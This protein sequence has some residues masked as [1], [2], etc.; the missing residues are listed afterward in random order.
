VKIDQI[1]GYAL[2]SLRQRQLRSWLTILGVVIGIAAIV[3]LLTI[4]EGFNQQVQQQLSALGENTVFVVPVAES[5]G[6]S[7]A[8]R[9][10]GSVTTSGKL[11]DEDAERLRRI[12]EIEE[13]AR[14]LSGRGTI[15]F[16][17]KEI[18]STVQGIEPGIFEKTTLVEIEEGRFLEAHDRR[19]AVVGSS[20]A[21]DS[22]GTNRIGV[23]S[24]ILI[25]GKKFRVIG[26]L[27]KTGGGFGPA[28]Q[29]DTAILVHFEDAQE[30]FQES[31]A[32]HEV[33]AIVLTL[34]EGSD[35]DDVTEK[36]TSEIAASHRIRPEDKDFSV[37]NPKVIQE[38]VGSILGLVTAF[39]GAIASISLLVG[40]VGIANV[41]F[42]SVVERTREIGVLKAV[43][44]KREDILRIFVFESAAL[45]GM[46]GGGGAIVGLTVVYPAALLGFP[47][48]IH[49]EIV[50]FALIFSIAVGFVSGFVPARRAAELSPV[51]ALRYE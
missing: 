29:M 38:Q 31:L 39:L 34:R 44:A 5:Q 26:I 18:S 43:G 10:P 17:E 1:A 3:S 24:F 28:A 41:M 8:F 30:L 6:S 12:P 36:I 13:I 19:V 2:K 45:G 48:A 40:G 22:F 4:G 27:Q 16:K 35:V 14:I 23:N 33:G 15:G 20:T 50:L 51:D 32:P 11:F 47:I 49:W 9:S 46:G 42:T 7:L 21:E 25:N 37:I